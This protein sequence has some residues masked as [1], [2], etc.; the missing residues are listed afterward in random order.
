MTRDR[1]FK[2]LVRA[3]MVKTGETYT[4]ARA[5]ILSKPRTTVDPAAPEP[6][7]DYATLAGFSDRT[8]QEK[9]GCTWARWVPMLDRL[10]AREMRHGEIAAL[11]NQKFKIDGWWSQA[12]AVGYERIKGRRAIGQRV[13]GS[14]EAG[15]SR[16]FG[17]PVATLFDAWANA[18]LRKRWLTDARVTVRTAVAPK[19][20]RLGWSDGTI[21]AVWFTP[22]GPD[23]ST[24]ALAHTKLAHKAEADRLRQYW[25]ERLD[26]LGETL[27]GAPNARRARHAGAKRVTA[28]AT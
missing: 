12:V 1:D 15:K 11:V 4:A 16:T 22:K 21:V 5:Q 19:S 10:G 2:R 25:G 26:A 7:K 6:P 28:A 3:R 24:V 8:I 9:T 27:S 23:R 17:V 18:R 13:D 14:Y 20:M